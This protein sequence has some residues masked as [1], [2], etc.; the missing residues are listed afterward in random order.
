MGKDQRRGVTV[1]SLCESVD[2]SRQAYYKGHRQR[3]RKKVDGEFVAELVRQQRRDHPRMG[4]RKLHKLL[5]PELRA[6]GV[7]LG[8][9]RMFEELGQR[10]LL[11]VRRPA[12]FPHTTNSRHSLPVFRNLI[13]DLKPQ[14]SNEVWVGDLMYLRTEEGFL[15]FSHLTDK[16]SRK[17]VG[18]HCGDTLE[19]EG[20]ME[21]LKMA[22]AG[23]PAGGQLIHH[24]DRGCQYACHEYVGML[25]ERAITV[26][27][28]ELNH[29]AENALAERVNGILRQEYGLGFRFKTKKDARRTA[30][31]AVYLYNE[32]RPHLSLD[33]EVPSLVHSG[34]RKAAAK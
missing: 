24:T 29:A 33:Y 10:D 28:T 7:A 25:E 13:K 31:R 17:I 26:S 18:Y 9:D 20:C 32:L 2:L 15:Y 6:A 19:A 16:Y 12:E 23:L 3:E 22:L 27:M 21:S 8:R 14:R 5:Q 34:H 11:V 30:S 1:S 4:T